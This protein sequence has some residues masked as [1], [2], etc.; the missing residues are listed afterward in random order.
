MSLD[1]HQI[2]VQIQNAQA[3]EE[4]N[5]EVGQLR[6]LADQVAAMFQLQLSGM[7]GR[8]VSQASLAKHRVHRIVKSRPSQM[9]LISAKSSSRLRVELAP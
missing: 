7:E 2:V 9:S 6:T 1:F 4:S 5:A 3:P 8:S